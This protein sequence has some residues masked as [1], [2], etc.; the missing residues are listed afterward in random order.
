VSNLKDRLERFK[1][2][3]DAGAPL[4]H[5]T[6]E[7]VAT[8]HRVTAELKSM[9]SEARALKVGDRTPDFMLFNQDHIEW[10]RGFFYGKVH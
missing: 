4:Y 1:K 3:F 9:G 6:P 5:A 2:N 10:R 8:M 7:V